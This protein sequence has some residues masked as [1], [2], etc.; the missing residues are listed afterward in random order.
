MTMKIYRPSGAVE[1]DR[2]VA[3]KRRT[4][5]EGGKGKIGVWRWRWSCD[6]R[7]SMFLVE[8]SIQQACFGGFRGFGAGSRELYAH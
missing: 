3:R 6:E 8:M 1:G 4:G 2:A 7:G 5:G